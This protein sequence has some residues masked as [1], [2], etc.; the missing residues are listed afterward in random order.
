MNISFTPDFFISLPPQEQS[1]WFPSLELA[2]QAR[3][4]ERPRLRITEIDP[5]R[6]SPDLCKLTDQIRGL[7]KS[8]ELLSN[9]YSE[10]TK[11]PINNLQRKLSPEE[12]RLVNQPSGQ[13]FFD[14]L[15][16]CTASQKVLAP[17]VTKTKELFP[18]GQLHFEL[19]IKERLHLHSILGM[20][21]S[22]L[23]ADCI[24]ELHYNDCLVELQEDDE[25]TSAIILSL[26]KAEEKKEFEDKIS[27]LGSLI[28]CLLRREFDTLRDCFQKIPTDE[29]LEKPEVD[30]VYLNQ[31]YQSCLIEAQTCRK[32]FPT[33]SA[34]ISK[35]PS[36]DIKENIKQLKSA[37]HNI[38]LREENDHLQ[39][40]LKMMNDRKL[41]ID[42]PND[43]YKK[44]LQSL[45]KICPKSFSIISEEISKKPVENW[46][47]K[48][49][50][51]QAS[52]L[53]LL[54]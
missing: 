44:I 32:T 53:K 16:R 17:L 25:R 18:D 10:E 21:S 36:E 31:L 6:L 24:H 50:L 54:K 15:D 45:E 28:K 20:T 3:H 27:Q 29:E 7:T 47:E 43:F 4:P 5:G 49:S 13:L 51:L 26:Q 8:A 35:Q 37:I 11:K 23:D 2:H 1:Q 34:E 39:Q 22:D 14:I 42:K 48:F 38:L 19:T 46:I 33:I 12:V 41:P 9:L 52:M 30:D 40:L